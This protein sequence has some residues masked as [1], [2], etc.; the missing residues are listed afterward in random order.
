M[1]YGF[2][3]VGISPTLQFFD[4]Q[5]RNETSPHRS[6]AYVGSYVCTLD[7]FIQ[8]TDEVAQKPD[9][10]WDE[11]VAAMIAFWIHQGDKVRQWR[12]TLEDLEGDNLIVGRV[13]NFDYMRGELEGLFKE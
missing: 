7:S 3:I 5:Q 8:A 12:A 1:S 4:H 6:K 13:A 11:V 9:W 2:D 10:D